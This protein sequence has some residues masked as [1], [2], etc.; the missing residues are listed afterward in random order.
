M[1]AHPGYDIFV[2]ASPKG[3][4][5]M[6]WHFLHFYSETGSG[7]VGQFSKRKNIDSVKKNK[8]ILWSLKL[9]RTWL[10][11]DTAGQKQRRCVVDQGP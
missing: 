8:V 6:L 2:T 1:F 11:M 7:G 9:Q 4:R 3:L 10:E 5:Q